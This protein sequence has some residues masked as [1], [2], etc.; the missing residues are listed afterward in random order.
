MVLLEVFSF[1]VGLII[2]L[3]GADV[4]VEAAARIAKL[5]GVS[6]FVIGLSLVAVGTSLP[7]LAVSLAAAFNGSGEI[8]FGNVL[9][10]NIAN[11]GLILGLSV[12]LGKA[13]KA[14]KKIFD[15]DLFLLFLVTIMVF[16][17]SLNS[18]ISFTEGLIMLLLFVAYVLYLF[19]FKLEFE[20]IFRF[21][22]YLKTFYNVSS[23]LLNLKIYKTIVK[24]GLDP[25]TYTALIREEKDGFEEEFGKRIDRGERKQFLEEYREEVFDRFIKNFY[26]FFIGGIGIWFGSELTIRGAV[27]IAEFLN[28]SQGVVGLTLVAIGTSLPELSVSFSSA[29]KGFTSIFLGNIIGSNIANSLLVLGTSALIAP[30]V[31]LLSGFTFSLIMMVV[32][33]A[34]LMIAIYGDWKISRAEAAF[35]LLLFLVFI[36]F[37]LFTG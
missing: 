35:F 33:T 34:A 27:S 10:S 18:V 15:T 19:K 16:Y 7:E 13:V 12:L 21:Q 26:L 11:I 28:I 36:Y 23:F 4:F 5:A 25:K 37:T 1:A 9:G 17:F 14:E 22:N 32:L 30:V 20:K 3:K 2:L 31:F 29:K 6:P 24:H 8:I